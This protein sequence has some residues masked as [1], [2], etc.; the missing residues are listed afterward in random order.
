[1][2]ERVRLVNGQFSIRPKAGEGTTVIVTIPLE[3]DGTPRRRR[4]SSAARN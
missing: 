2:Q 4:K 3:S 1:M